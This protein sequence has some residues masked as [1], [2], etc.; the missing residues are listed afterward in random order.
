LPIVLNGLVNDRRT[1]LFLFYSAIAATADRADPGA[2]VSPAGVLA[3]LVLIVGAF[4]TY[5]VSNVY[6]APLLEMKDATARIKAGDY[7]VRVGVVSN[8]VWLK[9]LPAMPWC[10]TPTA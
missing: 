1:L 6:Q 9:S 3:G 2:I 10:S 8:R 4:L 7:E 5:L